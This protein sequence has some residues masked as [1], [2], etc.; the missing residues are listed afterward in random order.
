MKKTLTAM[1]TLGLAA[2]PALAEGTVNVL[3]WEGYADPS[4]I[5]KFEEES[6]CKVSAT[7]VGSNDD[8]APKLLGGGGIYD[9][10]TPSIDTTALMID[11]GLVE[12]LDTAAI[13]GWNDIYPKFLSQEG[14]QRDGAYYG[15]PYV[16]G[17]IAF[18]YLDSA[19]PTPPTSIADLW[20]PELKGKISLWD[21]KS[22][23]YVAA[24]KNGD[25]DIYNLTDEQIEKAK[26]ALVEQKPLVRKYWATAGELVDLYKAG[27]VVISNT[28]AGYQSGLL[29]AEG[30][31]VTEFI[32]KEGAEGWMDSWM[33]VKDT[34]NKECAYKFLNMQ[35][36]ELG[37]CGVA[38]V[39]GYSVANAAAAK[40][41][42][43][44]EQYAALHQDDP[45]YLDSLQVWQALGDRF[46]AYT[47]AWNA[48]KAQ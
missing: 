39:N 36:S 48:V 12:P 37:Q 40:A 27:E 46:E 10:I 9:L 14:I 29:K 47:N 3:T 6:G 5:T 22:S 21:D 16:W 35:L 26:A 18:M 41:C 30:V 7:Y 11:L 8:F 44:A 4:F 43:P 33:V 2:G 25:M 13:T 23:I 28:W 15:M 38:N 31:K 20:N 19:F 42:M 34:P 1:L 17:A 45:N 32:P 24:R